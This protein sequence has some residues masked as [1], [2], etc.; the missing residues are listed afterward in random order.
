M[1]CAWKSYL[2]LLPI[3]LRQTVDDIGCDSLIE[4]RLR[5]GQQPEIVSTKGS[6]W[7]DSIVTCED[8]RFTINIASQYSAWSCMSASEGYIT[9]A[10]GHRIGLCGQ[11]VADGNNMSGIR[12]PS[13]VC[14]RVAKDITG[15]AHPAATISG[16]ILILGRPGSGKTTFLRDLIRQKSDKVH[17]AVVDERQELFP[18][19][20]GCFCFDP[21]KR[22]DVLSG[23]GK[24]HGISAVIRSMN[25]DYVAVDEITAEQDCASMLHAGWCGVSLLATAHAGSRRD[26]FSRPLYKPLVETN[27]FQN[28]IIMNS[29][30]SFTIERLKY[31]S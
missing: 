3:R 15:F 24:A 21:G 26:L 6:Q 22:T 10:G 14:I 23:C 13:S 17:V 7:L 31:D 4:L 12:V 11:A 27:L 2:N 8:L 30:R 25:P 1:K 19:V 16:S 5:C 29:D 28:L 18:H 9:A 20:A